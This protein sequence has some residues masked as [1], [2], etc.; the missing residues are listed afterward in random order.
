MSIPSERVETYWADCGCRTVAKGELVLF[1]ESCPTCC[2]EASH[3]IEEL[4]QSKGYQLELK[5]QNELDLDP[6]S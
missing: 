1:Q 3:W 4:I 2:E 6:P 5:P